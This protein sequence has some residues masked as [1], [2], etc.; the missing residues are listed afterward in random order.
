MT[1]GGLPG[2]LTHPDATSES[3][4]M[5]VES[6]LFV[7]DEPVTA[8]RLAAAL[9]VEVTE[10]DAALAEL[11][12]R[13]HGRG[14]RLQQKGDRV[15]LATMPE[16]AAAIERF[17]GLEVSP[18]LSPAALETLA[19]VAYRQPITRTQLEAVRGVNCDGVLRTLLSRGLIEEQGRLEAVGRPILYG[20]TFEFLQYF[21]LAQLD[22]L[23]ALP[24]EA[25][26]ELSARVAQVQLSASI[27][28]EGADPLADE[29]T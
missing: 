2:E 18:R 8:A 20:T 5:L 26:V 24:A 22:Q 23:P 27:A 4:T 25:A 3:L 11:G 21:G 6:L 7:A 14:V 16:A 28:D 10:V 29:L 13:L 12:Q 15:Q 9:G 19:M 17:L 1:F